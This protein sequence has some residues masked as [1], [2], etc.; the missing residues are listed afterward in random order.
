MGIN[1]DLKLT[2]Y[3]V[4]LTIEKQV[5][6]ENKE[7]LIQHFHEMVIENNFNSM[8]LFFVK[9]MDP[10]DDTHL[11]QQKLVAQYF[12]TDPQTLEIYLAKQAK[13]MR[14]Q[15]AD[16]LGR[17]YSISRRVLEIEETFTNKKIEICQVE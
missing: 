11:R 16:R 7:W 8:K 5:F 14:S 10:I 4:N 6:D 1:V 13:N 17:H 2:V 9:N 3:E 15:V 12:I